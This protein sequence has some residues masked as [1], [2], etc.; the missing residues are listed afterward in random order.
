MAW[1]WLFHLNKLS[2]FLGILTERIYPG[3]YNRKNTASEV[4]KV[5][6]NLIVQLKTTARA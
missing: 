4:S 6:W 5:T 1:D 3:E 2:S